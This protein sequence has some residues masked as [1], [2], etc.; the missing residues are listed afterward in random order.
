MI[1]KFLHRIP[2]DPPFGV[3]N[4]LYSIVLHE[5]V[6]PADPAA[7]QPE[8]RESTTFEMNFT[9]GSW[10]KVKK[11]KKK[12]MAAAAQQAAAAPGAAQP[13]APMAD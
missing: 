8:K 1:V 12:K 3:V 11:V 7:G 5:E 13:P 10:R 6:S 2:F 9:D 4:G